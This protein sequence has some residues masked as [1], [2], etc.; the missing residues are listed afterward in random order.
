MTFQKSFLSPLKW[1]LFQQKMHCQGRRHD[2]T[3]SHQSV[4][5]RVVITLFMTGRYPLNKSDVI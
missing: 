3:C 5:T 1:T 2:V 4:N